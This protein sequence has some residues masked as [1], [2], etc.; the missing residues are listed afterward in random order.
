M[1]V[2][3]NPETLINNKLAKMEK[4]IRKNV[5]KLSKVPSIISR[6]ENKLIKKY[7]IP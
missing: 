3:S 4:N 2:C 7:K 5:E 6:K 1:Y